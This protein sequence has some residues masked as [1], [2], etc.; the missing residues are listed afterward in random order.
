MK[1]ALLYGPPCWMLLG[2]ACRIYQDSQSISFIFVHPVCWGQLC[3]KQVNKL[4]KL[5]VIYSFLLHRTTGFCFA[6]LLQ[7]YIHFAYMLIK[8]WCFGSMALLRM[9]FYP[10]SVFFST[11]LQR[12]SCCGRVV[13][14]LRCR[15]CWNGPAVAI[16]IAFV[17]GRRVVVGNACCHIF[18]KGQ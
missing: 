10:L 13:D 17:V 8:M 7:V 9:I 14:I 2:R 18:G 12:G 11:L 5:F 15:G 1:L 6:Q 16:R 4:P 3:N